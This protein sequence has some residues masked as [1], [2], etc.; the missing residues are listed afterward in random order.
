[1]EKRKKKMILKDYLGRFPAWFDLRKKEILNDNINIIQWKINMNYLIYNHG[2]IVSCEQK[3]FINWSKSFE[4]QYHDDIDFE[5]Y[6]ENNA[7][8]VLLK[9]SESDLPPIL[10]RDKDRNWFLASYPDVFEY[11]YPQYDLLASDFDAE[12]LRVDKHVKTTRAE[13]ERMEK[14]IMTGKGNH[15]IYLIRMKNF[16]KNE[17]NKYFLLS[18]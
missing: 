18:C 6:L 8:K 14:V 13:F 2:S 5:E 3:A 4:Y 10:S 1:M 17:L 11:F 12:I 7:T 16:Y 15:T 9:I